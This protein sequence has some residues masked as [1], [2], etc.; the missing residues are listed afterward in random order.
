MDRTVV[1][2]A[3]PTTEESFVGRSGPNRLSLILQL[4]YVDNGHDDYVRMSFVE[5][6]NEFAMQ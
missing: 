4:K 1:T 3:S 5:Y 2:F 6:T